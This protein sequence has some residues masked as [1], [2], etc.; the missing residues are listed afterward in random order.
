M[1]H[2][3]LLFCQDF[4]N[5]TRT[6][7]SILYICQSR[8]LIWVNHPFYGFLS[9]FQFHLTDSKATS[10]G[11]KRR[12]QACV[13]RWASCGDVLPPF[14]YKNKEV[15]GEKTSVF[16]FSALKTLA[17]WCS[18]CPNPERRT[19]LCWKPATPQQVNILP[20]SAMNA[21][22]FNVVSTKPTRCCWSALGPIC[23][24]QVAF[25]LGSYFLQ[26]FTR[27][28]RIVWHLVAGNW[29]IC[30]PFNEIFDETELWQPV[31]F[32]FFLPRQASGV[33]PT[34]RSLIWRL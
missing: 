19:L 16:L 15:G 30:D 31:G 25:Q 22:V 5:K 28:L 18:N 11:V 34:T 23:A 9:L 8:A 26:S 29:C 17:R 14:E 4:Q 20:N 12:Q 33:F 27:F 6:F 32:G 1:G 24:R 7:L 10:C 13:R 21:L 3:I 2:G